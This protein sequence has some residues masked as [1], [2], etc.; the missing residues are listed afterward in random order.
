MK[1]NLAV[2]ILDP[3]LRQRIFI[4]YIQ[5]FLDRRILGII[6][7]IVAFEIQECIEKIAMCI[8]RSKESAMRQSVDEFAGI[9]DRVYIYI[10]IIRV[11]VYE[12]ALRRIT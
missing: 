10:P 2:V 5:N 6:F 7:R 1:I 3:K 11:P 4:I 9:M 8:P 12:F